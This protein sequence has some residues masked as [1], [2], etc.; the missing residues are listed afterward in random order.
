MRT[1]KRAVVEVWASETIGVRE[2]VVSNRML[3]AVVP[4]EALSIERTM[5]HDVCGDSLPRRFA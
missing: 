1:K 4:H 5:R 3:P 2:S